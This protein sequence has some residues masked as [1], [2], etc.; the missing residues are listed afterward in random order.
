MP[1]ERYSLLVS[2]T[3]TGGALT[4]SHTYAVDLKR[5]L[6]LSL[7]CKKFVLYTS[8]YSTTPWGTGGNGSVVLQLNVPKNNT[9]YSYSN[10]TADPVVGIAKPVLCQ[11]LNGQNAYFVS[12]LPETDCIPIVVDYPDN[13]SDIELTIT[14]FTNILVNT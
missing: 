2:D 14:T 5:I 12:R 1:K 6:P 10:P 8:F 7:K 13:W 9:R 4:E 3:C 11:Q